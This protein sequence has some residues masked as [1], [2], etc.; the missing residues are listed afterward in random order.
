MHMLVR[1]Q[2]RSSRLSWWTLILLGLCAILFGIMAIVWPHLT[3]LVFLYLFG[4]YAVIGG[5]ILVSNAFYLRKAPDLGDY[6]QP[7]LPPGE[8]GMILGEGVLSILAGLFCLFVP[9]LSARL[10]LYVVAT[11]TLFAGIGALIHSP[12]RGWLP[13]IAGVLAIVISLFLFFEPLRSVQAILWLL[14][15]CALIAGVLMIVQ[16]W[17]NRP[18]QE[19][20]GEADI[21]A[22]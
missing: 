18:L 1:S 13:G 4:V 14:G 7:D 6:S 10:S 3:F 17:L 8:W 12:S 19:R 16:G 9:T 2:N 11:W 22:M 20:P 21:S 15:V 5:L